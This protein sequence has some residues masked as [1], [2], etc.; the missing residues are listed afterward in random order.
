MNNNSLQQHVNEPTRGNNI[1]DLVMT[2]T[3]LSIIGLEV[4]DKVGDHQMI[5]F[6]LE[7]QDPKTRIQHKQVLDYKRAN[8]ELMKEELGS[9]NYEVLMNNKNA[10]ECYLIFKVKIAT[11]TDHY[12]PTKR[13]RPT[14]NPPWFSQEIKRLINA[15]QHSYRRLKRYQT[16]PHRQEHIH[17]CRAVKRT[18]KS[19]KR[20]KEITVAAQAKTNPKS[21]YIYVNDRRLKRDTIGPLIDFEG[22]T[23]TNNKSKA[24]ILNTYFTFVFTHEDLTE[25]PQPHVLN[26]QEI[27]SD[28]VLTV[29]ERANVTPIFK[30][31]NKQI[32]NNYR[33]IS[34]T[35]VISKTIERLLKVRITKHLNDQNLINDTKHGFREKRS[36]LTNFLDFF[37]EVNRIYDS[38]KAVD[39]VSLDFQKAFDKVPH[40]RLMAKV[41]AHGIRGCYSRWIRKWLTGRTQRVVIHDET[42]DPALETSGVPQGSVLGPLLFII[43]INDLDVGIISKIKKIADDTKLCHRAFTKRDRATIQSDL[44]RLLQWTETWQMSFNIEKCSVMH[45]G[46]NNRHFQHTMY[47][48]LIETV[49]QQRD[50][51]VIVTENF[52][53]DIQVGKKRQ[54]CEQDSWFHRTKL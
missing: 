41:E 10:E 21:F 15:R 14:N 40:E 16:E 30:K 44:N 4:K 35:S 13:I 37:G 17:A 28:D 54:K 2:T 46:A 52:K 19:T 36:C 47:N 34:L 53:H 39:F 26:T 5:N 38:K 12:I 20:N 22:S 32:P 24:K 23:P 3:D 50:L 42:S 45:V 51:G 25:I 48:V 29:E 6:S 18:I 43:Y 8:F 11:A 27:L 1:L 9:Y 33:P 7:V 49:Q 31:G